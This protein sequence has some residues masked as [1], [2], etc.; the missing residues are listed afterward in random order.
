MLY[1]SSTA[2]NAASG[3]WELRFDPLFTGRRGYAFPC[4]AQGQVDMDGLS[5]R[6][7]QNY[8]YARAMMGR[9]TSWPRVQSLMH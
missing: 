4:D 2:I 5:E 3:G 6:A 8:L 1:T 9:E 7:L